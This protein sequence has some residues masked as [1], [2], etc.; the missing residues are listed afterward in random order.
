MEKCPLCKEFTVTYDAYHKKVRCMAPFCEYDK[1]EGQK[2]KYYFTAEQSL[3][4]VIDLEQANEYLQDENA[5]L[6]TKAERYE[7][8]INRILIGSTPDYD[9]GE[10]YTILREA[11]KGII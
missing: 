3:Q 9:Y 2:E 10:I 11:L 4:A 6:K 1:P 5:E 8:A 7:T